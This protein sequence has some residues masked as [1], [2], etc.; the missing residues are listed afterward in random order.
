MKFY[1]KNAKITKKEAMELITKAQLNEAQQSYQ[2]DP[3]EQQSYQTKK[4]ILT[5]EF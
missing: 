3:L 2:M 1:L 4:G 5:I